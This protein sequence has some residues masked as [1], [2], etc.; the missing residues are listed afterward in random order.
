MALGQYTNAYKNVHENIVSSS[1]W[2]FLYLSWASQ[3]ENISFKHN[4]ILK[5]VW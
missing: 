5:L 3:Y 4:F 1:S 2:I